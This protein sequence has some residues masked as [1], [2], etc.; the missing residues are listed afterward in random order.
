MQMVR[1][2]VKAGRSH[3]NCA[4]ARDLLDILLQARDR[5]HWRGSWTRSRYAATR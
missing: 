4:R 1:D 5:G 3:S 2:R